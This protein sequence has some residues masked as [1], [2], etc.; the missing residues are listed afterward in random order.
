MDPAIFQPQPMGLRERMLDIR[1]DDRLSY[2]AASNTVYMNYAGMR[3]RNEEDIRA[4][5]AAVDATA[6]ARS[7]SACTRS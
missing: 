3:V 2:D 4:I 7:A 1:I 6:R 5:V